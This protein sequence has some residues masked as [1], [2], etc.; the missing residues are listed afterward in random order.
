MFLAQDFS[1][2][3]KSHFAYVDFVDITTA[4]DRVFVAST[5][6]I[7]V[8]DAVTNTNIEYTTVDGLSGDDIATLLYSESKALIVVGY[9]NGLVEIIDEVSGKVTSLVDIQNKTGVP[10]NSIKVNSFFEDENLLYIATGFGI[11]VYDLNTNLFG[12]TFFISSSSAVTSDVAS[13]AVVG[14]TIIASIQGRGTFSGDKNNSNL[15]EFA[16]WL[17]IQDEVFEDIQLFSGKAIAHNDGNSIFEFDGVTF[18]SVFSDEDRI[19][20]FETSD[21][22]LVVTFSNKVSRL[23]TSFVS[24]IEM[25]F[26]DTELNN[27]ITHA[28]FVNDEVYYVNQENGFF[29]TTNQQFQDNVTIGPD[30]PLL[31]NGFAI[32]AFDGD[33]WMVYG[34]VTATFNP[35]GLRK[36]KGSSRLRNNKWTNLDISKFNNAPILSEILINRS[37]KE[38]VYAGTFRGNDGFFEILDAEMVNVFNAENSNIEKS[39][40]ENGATSVFTFEFDTA[41]QLWIINNEVTKLLKK[42]KRNEDSSGTNFE[43]DYDGFLNEFG[44]F[45]AFNSNEIVR[46]DDDNFY[47][48]T[49]RDGLLGYQLNTNKKAILKTEDLEFSFVRTIALALDLTGDLWVGTTSGL[50]II[51]NPDRMFELGNN[52]KGEP[53]IFLDDGIPQE[54]FFQQAVADIKIDANNNKW[55]ATEGGAFYLSPDGQEILL[56]FTKDNSPLPSNNIIDIAIDESTGVVFFATDKGLMEY[57]AGVTVAQE[58]L[59][60]FKIFPNPVRPEHTD[61][62]VKI[63]GLTVGANVKITDVE[64]NLVFEA[65]N[66]TFGGQSSGEIEWDTRS[67]SGQKVASGVYLVLVTGEEGGQTTVGKILVVR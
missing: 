9:K 43:V 65:Q 52:V 12:D 6:T 36:R 21:S 19:L 61:V 50:R 8:H 16:N 34:A 4:E 18:K 59:E 40:F 5:N 28:T 44:T 2:N 53:V 38:Q 11:V 66:E 24:D 26:N 37:N 48:T 45:E 25:P 58:N 49:V 57:T 3:W 10:P 56:N 1:G 42:F 27:K 41:G 15:I 64:G 31:N 62:N 32:D 17:Q 22:F 20:D 67:F 47:F 13:V 55:I 35:G 14:N 7:F 46:D 39:T 60:K 54:L 23:T 63:Q 30:G 29:K 51:E 33:L